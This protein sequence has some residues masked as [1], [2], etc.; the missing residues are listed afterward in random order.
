MPKQRLDTLLAERGLFPSRSRAAASVMAGE[1]CVGAARRRAEKPGEMVDTETEVSVRRAPSLCLA[2]RCQARQRPCRERSI[3]SGPP[4]LGR[5]RLAP[6]GSPTAC[7]STALRW[8]AVDVGY[9]ELDY[10]LRTDARVHGARA[11]QRTLLTSAMLPY[12]PD[13]AVIDVSFISLDKD[14]A[15]RAG[16]PCRPTRRARAD[17]APVRGGARARRQGRG[18]A[19]AVRSP[20]GASRR[21]PPAPSSLGSRC[22]ASTARDCRGQRATARRSYGLAESARQGARALELEP[23][24]REVEP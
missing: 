19:F 22:S 10:G 15:C 14:P 21:R 23:M 24:A 13:L 5:R 20:R 2:G 18:G 3:D 7:Y 6:A 12:R 9:G 8:S 17:Q 16:L 1:V 4:G 11:H